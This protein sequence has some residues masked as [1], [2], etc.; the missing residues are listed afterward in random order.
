MAT[1]LELCKDVRAQAGVSGTGPSGV[2]GQTGIYADVVRWVEEAYNEIQT[3]HENW[4]FLHNQYSLPLP[5]YTQEVTMPTEGV[6]VI[7]KD[8]FIHQDQTGALERVV[9]VPY[10]VWKLTDRFVLEAPGTETPTHITQLPNNSLKLS[11]IQ[12]YDCF[13]NFEGYREPHV[14]KENLDIPIFAPQ[15]HDLIQFKA[16]MKYA[17]FYN[18]TETYNANK[19]AFNLDIK[20]MQFS[21][22]PRENI[23][24]PTFV[25]FA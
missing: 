8:T 16:L 7:A 18:A 13:I 6:R 10:S 3:M 14:M 1:F 25:P 24:T 2:T 11:A 21:E 5:A 4:N 15:Y 12:E 23:V 17:S 19:E 9:Y 20:K 22:L